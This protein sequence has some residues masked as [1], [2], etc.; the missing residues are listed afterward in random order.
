MV[1]DI[2]TDFV[3]FDVS[4]QWEENQEQDNKNIPNEIKDKNLKK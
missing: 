2:Q 1:R 3:I 4:D